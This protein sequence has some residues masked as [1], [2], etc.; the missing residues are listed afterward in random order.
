MKS[1]LSSFSAISYCSAACA[2]KRRSARRFPK[3]LRRFASSGEASTRRSCSTIWSS[4]GSRL[5][6]VLPVERLRRRLLVRAG[7][8]RG[9]AE[10]AAHDRE[11]QQGGDSSHR[12]RSAGVFRRATS[13]TLPSRSVTSKTIVP[14]C[15]TAPA[16]CAARARDLPRIPPDGIRS[17]LLPALSWPPRTARRGPA[18]TRRGRRDRDAP[19]VR[20][21]PGRR[22][23]RSRAPDE[24]P[25]PPGSRKWP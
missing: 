22:W 10:I 2:G 17:R 20:T 3:S 16:P 8:S 23:E 14:V 6:Q 15:R 19:L 12:H 18:R 13:R 7:Q 5:D 11:S 1:F 25:A 9:R 21:P 4:S 24:P